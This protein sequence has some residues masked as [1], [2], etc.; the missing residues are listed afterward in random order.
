[1]KKKIISLLLVLVFML[2]AVSPLSIAVSAASDEASAESVAAVMVEETWGNPRKTV[3]L[4]IVISENPGILGA[5]IT[6]SWD[7]SLTLVADASGEA[8]NHMTY[9]SPSRYIAS[10]TNF[11][12]FGNEVKEAID[13]TILTLTFEVSETAQNND[14]LPVRVSYTY[15]TVVDQNNKDVALRIADGYIRVITYRPGDVTG[16]GRVNALDLVRLSQYISDGCKTDPEGYNAEVVEDACDV[17]GDGRVNVR[18][19]IR[20]SQ[21]ISDGSQT[22]PD[23]YNAVLKP[24]K[25]PE[26]QHSDMQKTPAKAATCTESGNIEYWY[27]DKCG[28]YF[29]DNEGKSE[30]AA[31]KIMLVAMGHTY[32]KV[33]SGNESYHWH[34]AICGHTVITDYS[35][36]EFDA[37]NT[38]TV[39]GHVTQTVDY[40]KIYKKYSEIGKTVNLITA[41]DFEV[42]SGAKRLFTDAVYKV[43][44]DIYAL[45]KQDNAGKSFSSF[46]SYV[47]EYELNVSAKISFGSRKNKNNRF[48]TNK[49]PSIDIEGSYSYESK[50]ASETSEYIYSWDYVLAGTRVDISEFRNKEKLASLLSPEF[51]SDAQKIRDGKMSAA[52]FVT[53]WGTHVITSGIYG[54][55][56]SANYYEISNNVS[57][58]SNRKAALD[59]KFNMRFLKTGLDIEAGGDV[60]DINSSCEKDTI[61]KLSITGTAKNTFL[62]TSMDE[63]SSA[64]QVWQNNFE[65]DVENNSVLVDIGDAGLCCIWYLLD[66]SF[67]DVKEVLDEYMYSQCSDLYYEYESKLNNLKLRDDIVFDQDTGI[68]E[69]NLNTYQKNGCIDGFKTDSFVSYDNGILSIKPYY[70]GTQIKKIVING[71]YKT[72]DSGGQTID[73]LIENAS[74]K[75]LPGDWYDNLKIELRNVG[76]IGSENAS[77][78]DLTAVETSAKITIECYGTSCIRANN[79][80]SAIKGSQNQIEFVGD[81]TLS[82]RINFNANGGTSPKEYSEVFVY[83]SAT[84]IGELPV[85]TRIGCEFLGWKLGD[86]YVTSS[87]IVKPIGNHTLVADWLMLTTTIEIGSGHEIRHTLSWK[88]GKKVEASDYINPEFCKTGLLDAGYTKIQINVVFNH[89]LLDGGYQALRVCKPGTNTGVANREKQWDRDANVGYD[90]RW[91]D[92]TFTTFEVD[93]S[94]L[95]SSCDF[96]LFWTFYK[97][98]GGTDTYHVAYTKVTITAIK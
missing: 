76:I 21:Y 27:C 55:R 49:L 83:P 15:G 52:D 87:S 63:L 44:P 74:I 26:C 11:I 33:W 62:C 42:A 67:N 69:I 6:V 18:D 1:M 31:G 36:H 23:G 4:D 57:D 64:Y 97:D 32:S 65:K 77:V 79:G 78:I 93:L 14:V 56:L 12:W 60:S 75:L 95:D 35:K 86:E 39:C 37:N 68:L 66:D 16:D 19:L 71:A 81:G 61:K 22:S 7:E 48:M 25:M 53:L 85:P 8:F 45:G 94:S 29:V 28:K 90:I 46:S 41:S 96:D 2:S 24:A 30:I 73:T 10:G 5:T 54:A 3:D 40:E 47:D 17:T 59:A 89:G 72:L 50:K 20:M 80:M 9:T 92:N 13:G 58:Y 34:S 88:D 43:E 70:N 51:I 98:G 91:Y 38:C 84:P 82:Y